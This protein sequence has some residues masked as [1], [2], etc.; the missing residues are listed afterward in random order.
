[1]FKYKIQMILFLIND[2]KINDGIRT[3][4][5]PI[6]YQTLI[7]FING[8]NSVLNSFNSFSNFGKISEI[9]FYVILH[10]FFNVDAV[11]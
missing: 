10:P 1:M 6:P 2:L 9:S 11:L 4:A 3:M 7:R 8:L 5:N